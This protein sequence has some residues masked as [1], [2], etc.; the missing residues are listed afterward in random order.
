MSQSIYSIADEPKPGGL[1]H[2]VV[3][4]LWPLLAFM[5]GGTWFGWGWFVLNGVALGSATL[6]REI[7]LVAAGFI[8]S[9]VILSIGGIFLTSYDSNNPIG[10]RFILLT[11]TVWKLTI[12][13]LL[14]VMQ[15][16]SFAI[17]SY[18]NERV[19]NGLIIVILGVLV[20]HRVIAA[21][22][23]NFLQIILD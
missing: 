16:R 6:R 3:N 2:L 1:S 5:L 18:Y 12:S 11:V 20:G 19:R 9:F 23:S 4:P 15:E 17:Y 7:S 8:G 22:S 14:Y 10:I 21:L 13:Y